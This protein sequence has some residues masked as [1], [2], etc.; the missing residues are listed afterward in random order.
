MNQCASFSLAARV[1]FMSQEFRALSFCFFFRLV[2]FID[3]KYTRCA[4]ASFEFSNYCIIFN[5]LEIH[6]ADVR[7]PAHLCILR[8]FKAGNLFYI[9]F[10][11]LRNSIATNC[12]RLGAISDPQFFA[13]MNN[14]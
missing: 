11:W 2:R 8:E 10:R 3:G 6:H 4:F 13:E 1:Y 5:I 14:S 12:I 9:F 7:V